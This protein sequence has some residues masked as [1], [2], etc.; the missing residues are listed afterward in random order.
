MG[1]NMKLILTDFII[2]IFCCIF[3]FTLPENQFPKISFIIAVI[4]TLSF[5]SFPFLLIL[6]IWQII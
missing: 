6:K 5:I 2:F 4:G 3:E 1:D